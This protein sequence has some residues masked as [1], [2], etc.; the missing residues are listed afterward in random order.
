MAIHKLSKTLRD[1]ETDTFTRFLDRNPQKHETTITFSQDQFV[2]VMISIMQT[3][4]WFLQSG[5]SCG[6]E[7]QS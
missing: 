3:L 5:T 2:N 4:A 6:L 1:E 7:E